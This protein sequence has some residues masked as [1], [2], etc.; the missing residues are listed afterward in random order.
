MPGKSLTPFQVLSRLP[1]DATPAQQDSAVQAN[2]KISEIHWSEMPDTLHMPGHTKG[3]GY[4]DIDIPEHYYRESFFM[5][6]SLF[7]PELKG[8]RQGIAGVVKPYTIAGDDIIT[9]LLF[10]CFILTLFALARTRQFMLRQAKSIFYLVR[11]EVGETSDEIW[12][13]FYMVLQTCL[14]SALIVFFFL[15]NRLGDLMLSEQY[16]IIGALSGLFVGYLLLK[17]F[18][19]KLTGWVFFNGKK[20]EQWKKGFLFL[21][22]TEG[23]LLFPLVILLAYADFPLHNALIY[24][25]IV[26]IIVKLLLLYKAF[27]IFFRRNGVYLQIILYFCAIE[28]VPLIVLGGILDMASQHLTINF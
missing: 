10:G 22:S 25:F 7:H 12:M 13:L 14:L 3:K 23:L 27:I 5:K 24:A 28:I 21:M 2:V 8:G 4:H 20:N 17:T 16:A 15:R 6:D 11:E 26:I 19:Y 18:M 1:E 9:S